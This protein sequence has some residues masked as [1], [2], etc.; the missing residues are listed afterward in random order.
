M[1]SF[2]VTPEPIIHGFSRTVQL[3]ITHF[4]LS[5]VAVFE[6]VLSTTPSSSPQPVAPNP[7]KPIASNV[8]TAQMARQP[9][10]VMAVPC[11]EWDNLKLQIRLF[12]IVAP[13]LVQT[14]ESLLVTLDRMYTLL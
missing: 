6:F 11:F 3:K 2:A 8:T 4:V 10:V 14:A 7:L 9:L 13:P 5:I 1:I 12:F